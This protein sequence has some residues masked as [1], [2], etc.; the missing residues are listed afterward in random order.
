MLSENKIRLSALSLILA[1]AGAAADGGVSIQGTR[2]IYGQGVR[3][4]RIS[5]K[6][7]S[8]TDS[9]LVQSWV[10]D[11]E[12]K[13]TDDFIVTPPLFLSSPKNENL[14]RLMYVGGSLPKDKEKLYYFISKEIPSIND[15]NY[16]DKSTLLIST[17]SKIKLFVRP[18]G[19]NVDVEKARTMLIFSQAER[20]MDIYNPSPYF[21]TLTDINYGER[22][23]KDVMVAPLSHTYEELPAI[24]SQVVS[25]RT[26]N[27]YGAVTTK[28]TMQ[29]K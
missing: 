29:I 7:S 2:I 14:I 1:A 8:A 9:F 22:K 16:H 4:E 20:K 18:S 6:N 27:D 13:K 15:N 26:I 11:A 5:V 24:K 19:L 25:F 17:A 28:E 12:G 23:I 3:Q 21:I 10:E